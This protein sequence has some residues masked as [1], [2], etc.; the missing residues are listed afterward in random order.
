MATVSS[1]TSSSASSELAR[2][3]REVKRIQQQLDVKNSGTE[4]QEFQKD[5]RDVKIDNNATA[6]DIGRLQEN[7][8]RLNL[9]SALSEGDSVDVYRFKVITTAKTTIGVLNESREVEGKVR[10]Q[11]FNKATGRLVAD[12]AE[13]A[14]EAKSNWEALRDGTFELNSGDYV[15]RVS[16]SS[17]IG[18]ERNTEYSYALQISQGLYKNDYDTIERAARDTDDPYG[19]GTGVSEATTTLTSSIASSVSFLQNLP[20]IGTPASAKLLGLFI[21]SVA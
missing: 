21:S 15:L 14:G 10:F 16:R 13:K 20:P 19:V 3:E 9:F 6:R 8:N 4:V 1:S 11:V 18:A 17:N 5:S 2:I 12:S 7:T